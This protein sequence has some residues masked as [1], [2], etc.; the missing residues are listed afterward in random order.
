M[1]ATA[2]SLRDRF[3]AFVTERFPFAVDAV[4]AAIARLPGAPDKPDA[5]DAWRDSAISAIRTAVSKP[6][7]LPDV[8]TTPGV[9]AAQRWSQAVH[10]LVEAC[11]GF[12]RR[13]AIAASFSREE[14]VEMLRGMVLT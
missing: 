9:A 2:I 11:D 10:V 5:L 4:S 6:A 3:A 12:L 14:R 13:E 7:A 1:R 8:E